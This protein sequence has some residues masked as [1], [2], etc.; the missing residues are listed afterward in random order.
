MEHL[1]HD[2]GKDHSGHF[3]CFFC[4]FGVIPYTS[5]HMTWCWDGF[6]VERLYAL[7]RLSVD[8]K[9]FNLSNPEVAALRLL[10]SPHRTETHPLSTQPLPTGLF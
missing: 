9:V 3:G 1:E 4:H 10:T 7:F 5:L 8:T 2:L 6:K